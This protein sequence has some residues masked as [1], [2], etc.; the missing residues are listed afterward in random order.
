M[1]NKERLAY[2]V[3]NL[4]AG[5]QSRIAEKLN[6]RRTWVCIVFSGRGISNRVLTEAEKMIRERFMEQLTM[7][8]R[9]EPNVVLKVLKKEKQFEIKTTK[10][11]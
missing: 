7:L 8:L 11:K 1:N 2:V 5:D 10:I 4:R 3:S 6:V 9:N